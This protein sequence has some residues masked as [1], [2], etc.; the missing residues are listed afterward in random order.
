MCKRFRY[1]GW[2]YTGLPTTWRDSLRMTTKAGHDE[3]R[4]SMRLVQA[5]IDKHWHQRFFRFVIRVRITPE[6]WNWFHNS[7]HGY[8]GQYWHSV[9]DG[10]TL[11][12]RFVTAI[13]GKFKWEDLQRRFKQSAKLQALQVPVEHEL[14]EWAYKGG[15][16]AVR[17]VT[18]VLA[19]SFAENQRCLGDKSARDQY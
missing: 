18:E 14:V 5:R 17:L 8:R 10:N 4:R 13:I 15:K 16:G 1:A 7:P 9:Q 19:S 3:I 11:N 2:T 12:Q 6:L